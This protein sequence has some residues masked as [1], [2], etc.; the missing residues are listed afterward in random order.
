MSVYL[1]SECR[2]LC[3]NIASRNLRMTS[4]TSAYRLWIIVPRRASVMQL[5]TEFYQNSPSSDFTFSRSDGSTAFHSEEL[6]YTDIFKQQGQAILYCIKLQQLHYKLMQ[7]HD[8]HLNKWI[9]FLIV[10]SYLSLQAPV[11][12]TWP[13]G[14]RTLTSFSFRPRQLTWQGYG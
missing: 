9:L 10:G 8:L 7:L 5:Y 4:Y 12:S 3:G 11:H 6:K 1:G 2:S 13:Q 14:L